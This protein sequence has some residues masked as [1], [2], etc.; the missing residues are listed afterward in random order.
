VADAVENK[1]DTC[2]PVTSLFSASAG[3][4]GDNIMRCTR[5]NLYRLVCVCDLGTMDARRSP[6]P[7]FSEPGAD[8]ADEAAPHADV[9]S[10]RAD[11][12]VH[13]SGRETR[14]RGSRV[15]RSD[16][17]ANLLDRIQTRFEA[18]RT[19][20]RPTHQ[21]FAYTIE[22]HEPSLET[23]GVTA[24]HPVERTNDP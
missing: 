20:S 17:R 24:S 12:H 10:V 13:C 9:R 15:A 6:Y 5:K 19:T 1:R 3:I 23:I 2:S 22:M 11:A 7:A 8:P 16:A 4:S 14:L 21:P 18:V